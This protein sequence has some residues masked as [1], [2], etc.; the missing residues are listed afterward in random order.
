MARKLDFDLLRQR[1]IIFDGAEYA[2]REKTVRDELGAVR[3]FRE[4]YADIM[5]RFSSVEVPDMLALKLEETAIMG[6]VI[7]YFCN[8]PREKIES[9]PVRAFYAA[10]S[11]VLGGSLD[12]DALNADEHKLAGSFTYDG[13]E[14]EI[15]APSIIDSLQIIEVNNARLSAAESSGDIAAQREIVIDIASMCVDMEREKFYD[16]PDSGLFWIL[17]TIFI[18]VN[19]DNTD[20]EETEKNV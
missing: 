18:S 17:D 6:D 8:M 5:T 1:K 3:K 2:V 10:H 20:N 19:G 16:I 7:S 11:Y 4:R 13:T 15:K 9:M 12:G 14:Y